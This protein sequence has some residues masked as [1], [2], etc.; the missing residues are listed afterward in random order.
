M[1][2]DFLMLAVSKCAQGM[3]L[4]HSYLFVLYVLMKNF[5]IFS[6]TLRLDLIILS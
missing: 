5:R 1:E 6:C 3:L 4:L 2:E